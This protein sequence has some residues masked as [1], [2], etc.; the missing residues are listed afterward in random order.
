[1]ARKLDSVIF[2]VDVKSQKQPLDFILA[3][4]SD[5][6]YCEGQQINILERDEISDGFNDIIIN[7]I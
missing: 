4:S 1:M 2:F 5:L 3:C 6:L 7:F